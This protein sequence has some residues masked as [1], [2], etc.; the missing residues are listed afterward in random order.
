MSVCD[1]GLKSHYSVSAAQRTVIPTPRATY[2]S[3]ES[4]S[5]TEQHKK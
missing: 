5:M 4:L 1:M 3:F 2:R